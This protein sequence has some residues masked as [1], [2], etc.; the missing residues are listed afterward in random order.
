[1]LPASTG[2]S[3]R[4][5]AEGLASGG[6]SRRHEVSRAA[7]LPLGDE[8]MDDKVLAATCRSG[9]GRRCDDLGEDDVDVELAS[10]V[11][12]HR[13]QRHPPRRKQPPVAGSALLRSTPCRHSP[14]RCGTRRK[15]LRNGE[16]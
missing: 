3:Q 10:I 4:A 9:E 2:C 6:K 13:R 14:R 15:M 1:M 5:A 8:E 16:R 7:P 11:Q 12:G